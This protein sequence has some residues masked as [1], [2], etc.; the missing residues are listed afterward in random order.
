MNSF[1]LLTFVSNIFRFVHINF[2]RNGINLEAAQGDFRYHSHAIVY[3]ITNSLA[4][5]QDIDNLMF[6]AIYTI[7]I[8]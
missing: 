2:Q 4:K 5:Y 6:N 1:K 8:I 7:S 3:I